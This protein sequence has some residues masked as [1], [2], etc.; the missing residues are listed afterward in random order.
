[1]YMYLI[2]IYFDIIYIYNILYFGNITKI[3][4]GVET[5]T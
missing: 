4:I 5:R 1:M 2:I 3:N